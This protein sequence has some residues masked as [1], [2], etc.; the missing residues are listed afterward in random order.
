MKK[1]TARQFNLIDKS[2]HYD[3]ICPH[4]QEGLY[5]MYPATKRKILKRFTVKK[6]IKFTL[7]VALAKHGILSVGKS[8]DKHIELNGYR[9]RALNPIT[10]VIA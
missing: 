9:N 2:V 4:S 10:L 5:S 1:K 8:K 3:N 6:A 7:M